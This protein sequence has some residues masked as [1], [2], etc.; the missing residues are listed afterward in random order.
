MTI[1]FNKYLGTFQCRN[2][3]QSGNN[4]HSA[5][6]FCLSPSPVFSFSSLGKFD[7]IS[8]LRLRLRLEMLSNFPREEKEN[9][10]GDKQKPR[11]EIAISIL[12]C[13]RFLFFR[14][15]VRSFFFVFKRTYG[16]FL[17][18]IRHLHY[19]SVRT[20]STYGKVEK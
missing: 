7:N 19:F 6:G 10:R 8:R 11:T 15:S 4:L 12:D 3:H 1:Q 5:L 14:F 18:G 16:D 17:G 2:V 20:S 13:I 9:S